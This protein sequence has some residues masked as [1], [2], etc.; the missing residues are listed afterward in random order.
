MNIAIINMTCEGSTGK[1]MLQLTQKARHEGHNAIAYTPYPLKHY[2]KTEIK[3]ANHIYFSSYF[4]RKIHNLFGRITGFNGLLSITGTKRL[5]KQLKNNNTQLIHL[6]NL[7]SY[8]I[9]LPILFR[10]IKK[11]NIQVF[12][13]FHDCWAFTGHCPHFDMIGCDKWKT[14][15][16]NCPQYRE[17]PQGHID[18]SSKMYRLKKKWFTGVE[19][20]TIITP[21]RWLADLVKESYLKDYP[22]KVIH[23]GI[24]LSIFKPTPSS[25][26]EK[27]KISES[28][29]IVLG[30]AFDWGVRKGLDVF[31]ALSERLD[32]EQY[33]I[34]LVGTSD[35]IDKKLPK[36]ILSIHK[37]QNQNEL[38]EIYT[39]A[40]IFVNPTR[41]E[42][43][44]LVNIEALAC[45]T[46]VLTFHTGG[47]P[48]IL[49]DSCGSVIAKDDL[50]TM[51]A[52]IK[53]ICVDKPYPAKACVRRA[54]E[55]DMN[56]RFEEYVKLYEQCKG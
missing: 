26:R 54:Q 24:D 55:F 47:S 22:V 39:A 28:K 46:P 43:L 19:N 5:V 49:D 8:C 12:W 45:G 16:R 3:R 11:Q 31:A 36:N 50:D 20:M 29:Y 51:E 18:T 2:E 42:A 38:V 23:N 44:G 30:V 13:T 32:A 9:N 14:F 1:I 15:C 34:V 56:E 53:R 37:T 10:Y 33:Q 35:E 21:S 17:Y 25:F 52:E 7:H 6:H 4:E 41:E 40:D 48:E 27:H